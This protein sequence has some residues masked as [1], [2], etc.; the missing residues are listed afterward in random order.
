MFLLE[1]IKCQ[2]VY[3]DYDSAKEEENV[4]SRD[5]VTMSSDTMEQDKSES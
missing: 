4:H 5:A 2:E 3:I 1:E